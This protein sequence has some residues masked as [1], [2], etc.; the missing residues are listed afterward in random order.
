MVSRP[1]GDIDTNLGNLLV[2]NSSGEIE[3]DELL[4]QLRDILDSYGNTNGIAEGQYTRMSSTDGVLQAAGLSETSSE[5]IANKTLRVPGGSVDLEGMRISNPGDTIIFTSLINAQSFD[6]VARPF[7]EADG[8]GN[9]V[10]ENRVASVTQAF[11]PQEAE[12]LTAS[13]LEVNIVEAVTATI[14]QWTTSSLGGSG[15]FYVEIYNGTDASGDVFWRSHSEGQIATGNVF[16]MDGGN[17]IHDSRTI[18][19]NSNDIPRR[20][21]PVNMFAGQNY[22]VRF[23]AVGGD[24]TFRGRTLTQADIDAPGSIFTTVGQQVPFFETTFQQFSLERVLT[25]ADLPGMPNF[26]APRVRSFD[27]PT[28][29]DKT[30]EAPFSLTGSQTFTYTIENAQ[31]VQTA[32][33]RQDGTAIHTLTVPEINSGTVDVTVTDDTLQAGDSVTFTL[34]ITDTMSGTETG[35]VTIRSPEPHEFAYYGV[36]ATN[37]FVGVAVN[38]LTS[39]DV[40]QSGTEFHISETLPNTQFVGILVPTNRDAETISALGG[41]VKDAFIRTAN[42]RA[43]NGVQYILYTLQNTSGFDGPIAYTV[44]TE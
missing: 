17:T 23:V 40:T 35:T 43:I 12:T 28:I 4:Q 9:V 27:I 24:F 10:A 34:H 30:P 16:T 29:T 20:S 25:E 1:K 31:N 21:N 44:V 19:L 26:P 3:A 5:I 39:V 14:Y 37:D 38:L 18:P 32:E 15:N 36:R 7:S 8:S 13:V 6:A 22:F 2:V 41:D 33:I 11:Q 42:A